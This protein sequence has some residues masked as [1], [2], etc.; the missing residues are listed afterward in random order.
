MYAL[1]FDQALHL[2]NAEPAPTLAA[3]EALIRLRLAGICQ[4]DLELTRG[5]YQF[6]GILGHE[7]VGE[8]VHDSGAWSAGQRVVGE[9]NVACRQCPTCLKGVPSQC[10]NRVT[11][12]I[13]QYP[14]TFA[15][16]L[17]LPLVNLFP[18]PD[19]VR[20][21]EAVFT[22]PLAA[23]LQIPELGQIRPTD[24]V[25]LI[26]AG[27]LGLLAAQ[28]IKLTGCD[29]SVVARRPRPL[30]LLQQWNIHAIDPA[31]TDLQALAGTADVV[32]ECAGNAEGFDLALD[33]LRPRG[34]LMLKST[35]AGR[36]N[37]DLSRVVVNEIQIS[38][39]RCGP[40]EPALRLLAN[41]LVDVRSMI[42]ATYP[43]RDAESAFEHA[44]RA[45]T[46]K[47]L[48]QP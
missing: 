25:I 9:I 46:L 26:G 43:L 16:Y 8:L 47:V 31:V 11:M 34:K 28:V 42:E 15:E 38:T 30:A 7:F 41:K 12:G 37:I 4:T 6:S 10:P 13:N 48:L 23:A 17:R 22:E 36:P 19:S 29:L 21:D 32:V 40:F 44:A 18:V 1:R 39:S 35:Y 3:D 45:G 33:L 20:D 5:Y 2:N 27:K 14:G 24:R